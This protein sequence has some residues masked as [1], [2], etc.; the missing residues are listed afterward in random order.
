MAAAGAEARGDVGW[1]A[2]RLTVPPGKLPRSG[3][4]ARCARVGLGATR[5]YAASRPA[6]T[7]APKCAP[8]ASP[9]LRPLTLLATRPVSCPQS[10]APST[11]GAGPVHPTALAST[12]F[13]RV[14][15][16]RVPWP[17]PRCP[18]DPRPHP[19]WSP[20]GDIRAAAAAPVSLDTL[21]ELCR[22][23]KL[24]C[25]S[26][27]ITKRNLNN[28]EVEYLCDYKVVKD[29]E[30]YLVK[31]KGWPDS[32]NTWEP[33][34]NLKCPLLLQQFSKD[35]HNYL[36]QVKKGKAITLKDNNKALRP[37]IAKY[38]VKKA[39]QRI[40]LQ[41]WQDE[42]NRKKNHKGMIFV[43][44]T[45]D[46]EGP[47]SDF[48]YINEYKPAP[49]ISLVNEATFGCSC[50][51]CFFEKCCPA[52][53]GVL[54]AYNKNQQ[55]KIPP[56]TPIYECN[57]RCQCGPDCP[58]RIVQKGTPY[59]LCIFRTSNGCG[60]GVKT[61]VKIKRMSFVMEYVG[62]VITSEEA[63]RRGQLYDNKGITYLFDLDYESDEF[64]VDAA[65]YGNCDPNLQVFNVFIDN[66]D[67]RLPRIALFSTRT[68]SAGEELTFDYQMKGS[69]D[70]SS[71][72]VDHSPAKKRVRTVCKC[73][74]VTCRGYLN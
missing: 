71:D 36:S 70:V 33:L 43:E 1:R 7:L 31:W 12:P 6:D 62:E 40:A 23:E 21:Q 25:Q 4:R 61:L 22:K 47:P 13:P 69:G 18:L 35:K 67:T 57:S 54:L 34:Q 17:D 52:E 68:I 2:A 9:L 53:A 55:I 14:E 5:R 73:G 64:T 26:I 50:T 30:Y 11:R 63:E 10:P 15:V 46:L 24:T 51:D 65:R 16:L 19:A 42:L 3:K 45:V 28:Y 49:G 74:A 27:G 48:F 66:L 39:K 8:R 37:A 41:R 38:I 44:N 29:M 60:W 32:T 20:S 59:S 72:S 58:N 56:G